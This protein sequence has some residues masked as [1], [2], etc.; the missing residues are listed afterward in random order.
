MK[1]IALALAGL[2][3]T[4]GPF[5]YLN[6]PKAVARTLERR[7]QRENPDATVEVAC[8]PAAR[9]IDNCQVNLIEPSTTWWIEIDVQI[10]PDGHSFKVIYVS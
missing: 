7:I 6:H 1:L 8:A 3:A 4:A 10:A 2:V 5:N 9:R